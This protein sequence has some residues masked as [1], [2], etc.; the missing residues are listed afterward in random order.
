MNEDRGLRIVYVWDIKKWGKEGANNFC[1]SG[2]NIIYGLY[3]PSERK[4]RTVWSKSSTGV[5]WFTP[6][7]RRGCSEHFIR[8]LRLFA[9]G[10]RITTVVR[11]LKALM[12]A[13]FPACVCSLRSWLPVVVNKSWELLPRK[14]AS[15]PF[16][17]TVFKCFYFYT[18]RL[19][20]YTVR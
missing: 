14:D 9:L 8:P 20:L 6:G 15:W 7:C 10:F 18:P 17:T 2:P 5:I 16:H 12:P 4:G 11:D 19:S 1:F 13:G 3:R